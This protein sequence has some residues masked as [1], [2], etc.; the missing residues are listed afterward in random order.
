MAVF[1]CKIALAG[2]Q[3]VEQ[4][5]SARSKAAL[6]SR[7]E[8]EG[9]F[10]LAIEPEKYFGSLLP[11]GIGAK[12]KTKDF[13]SFNEAFSVLLRSGLPV[14]QALESIREE[15]ENSRLANP[16]ESIIEDVKGGESLSSAFQKYAHIFFPLYIATLQS[17]EKSGNLPAAI[18][19]YVTY[20]KKFQRIKQKLISA[21]IYPLILAVVSV[22]VLIFLLVV[23]VPSLSQT[24]IEAGSELPALTRWMLA[25]SYSVQKG[26]PVLFILIATLLGG[27]VLFKKSAK[28]RIVIDKWK[29][30]FPLAGKIYWHYATA[31][32]SR[33][34]AA[35]LKAGHPLLDSVDI[36]RQTLVNSHME[37]Q[38]FIVGQK[39][40]Q[41]ASLSQPL[42]EQ[43]LFPR[44][45]LKLITAGEKG[46][47]LPLVLGNIAD[48]YENEMEKR[49]TALSSV[50]EPMLMVVMGV[51]IGIIVLA[52]YMPI[53]NLG[54]M[55]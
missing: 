16:L 51:L 18:S 34:L 45:A 53:F 39:L 19:Q 27:L 17:G 10:V 55:F 20:I 38:L 41:G 15:S 36:A 44:T 52:M 32:F 35:L 4:T 12:I 23:V 42:S 28:G 2:G 37:R 54:S 21:A 25:I 1:K 30:T 13:I 26:W 3:V 7:L 22:A 33:S 11:A 50:I 24:F 43:R 5:L 47:A 31:K 40:R 46:G 6:K 29:L 14:V 49:L 48:Y 8:Q 9:N